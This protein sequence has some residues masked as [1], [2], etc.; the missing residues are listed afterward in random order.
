[1]LLNFFFLNLQTSVKLTQISSKRESLHSDQVEKTRIPASVGV[2][3][4]CIRFSG[5]QSWA[6]RGPAGGP[7]SPALQLQVP[8]HGWARSPPEPHVPHLE[9]GD[10]TDHRVLVSTREYP[11][12]TL[13]QWERG[14][15]GGFWAH[16]T[17]VLASRRGSLAWM[18]ARP[19]CRETRRPMQCSTTSVQ[20]LDS[21][22]S[23]ASFQHSLAV[24]SALDALHGCSRVPAHLSS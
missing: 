24:L 4:K 5:T 19:F 17:A 16:P 23:E 9:S 22:G 21:S 3:P 1:M 8:C 18:R 6:L 15:C 7:Q 14:C 11:C 12:K 13:T 20:E 2:G 10:N